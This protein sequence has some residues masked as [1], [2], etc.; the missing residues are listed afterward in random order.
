MTQ[1][2]CIGIDPGFD[3]VGWA[4]GTVGSSVKVLAYGCIQTSEELSQTQRYLSIITQL[5]SIIEEHNPT[6]AALETLYFARNVSTALP[7]SEARGIILSQLIPTCSIAE[8]A[9][10]TIKL[11]VTGHGR[12][13]KSAVEKMVRLQLK[14]HSKPELDD[15]M[16]ALAVLLTHSVLRKSL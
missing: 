13:T 1:P 7:V 16:D 3:R 5:K 14:L 10:G 12:A 2:I 11:A 8:Y 9:P 4:V 15:T 6:E